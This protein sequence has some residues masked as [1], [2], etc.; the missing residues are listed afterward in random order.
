MNH[1]WQAC[2]SPFNGDCLRANELLP[3]EDLRAFLAE[4]VREL[5]VH[6]PDQT[7]YAFD[8]WHQHDGYITNRQI[9]AWSSLDSLGRSVAE[10]IASRQ[11]DC[12]VHRSFYSEDLSFLL[13]VDVPDEDCGDG[14]GLSG[15][16]DLSANPQIIGRLRSLAP[17]I[18][19]PRLRI[20]PSKAYFD[21]T[22]AG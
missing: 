13:R 10:L 1:R 11:G 18:L 8:D 14:T 9:T 15:T 19:Q 17:A 20:E 3:V 6:H 4:V 2:L 7:I 21:S 5:K 16:F 22:Y 12:Y